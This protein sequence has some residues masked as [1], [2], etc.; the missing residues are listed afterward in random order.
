M[1]RLRLQRRSLS[2]TIVAMF[3]NDKPTIVFAVGFMH[4]ET[5]SPS[6]RFRKFVAIQGMESRTVATAIA[7]EAPD[8]M[9]VHSHNFPSSDAATIQVESALLG[10]CMMNQNS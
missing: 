10:S 6:S 8:V 5:S 1:C 2:Y 3:V 9:N 4:R 7:M